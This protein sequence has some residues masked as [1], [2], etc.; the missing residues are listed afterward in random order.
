[1]H[2][3]LRAKVHVAA[4]AS[5]SAAYPKRFGAAVTVL[6]ADGR[7]VE[8]GVES[9]KGDPENPLT[10][11]AITAKAEALMR[12]AGLSDGTIA[13]L[14]SSSRALAHGAPVRELTVGLATWRPTHLIL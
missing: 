7:R 6:L 8:N 9:A 1:M 10:Q 13:R 11:A 12:A 4:D 5:I 14:V 3:D 2:R